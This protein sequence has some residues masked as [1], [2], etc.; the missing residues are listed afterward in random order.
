MSKKKSK[1]YGN[2]DFR[3]SVSFPL[4]SHKE[5]E[6]S[7]FELI[8]PLDFKPPKSSKIRERLL[9]LPLFVALLLTLVWRKIPSLTE[10]LR[11]LEKEGVLGFPPLALTKQAFSK[12]LQTIPSSLFVQICEDLLAR[13]QQKSLQTQNRFQKTPSFS[14]LWSCDGSTL[15]ALQKR[16]KFDSLEKENVFEKLGGKMLV[17]VDIISYLPIKIFYTPESQKNDKCFASEALE[18]LPTGG[19]L[20]LDLGFFCFKLFDR[21]TEMGKYFVTRMREKTA[22][23]TLSILGEGQ[24]W[25]DE[26]IQ[27]GQYRSNPCQHPVRMISVLWGKTWRRYITNVLDISKLSAR[28]VCEMYQ[29]RWRIEDAFSL[30][31]RLLGL[32][33]LKVGHKNGVEMQVYATWVFYGVLMNLCKEVAEELQKPIKEISVEMVFRSL[34]HYIRAIQRGENQDVVIFISELSPLFGIV[35]AKRKQKRQIDSQKQMV[36][37]GSA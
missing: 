37:A 34:Y 28:E 12:R 10:L 1:S 7:L 11:V 19:L 23:Q 21:F 15:E 32:S 29:E 8:H 17:L 27:M 6:S 30:T 36:W 2:P 18:L 5:L 3:R 20:I 31:K 35:K 13:I 16:L 14:A 22:Y 33:Y 24:Y 25:K 26:L 9:K 4:P